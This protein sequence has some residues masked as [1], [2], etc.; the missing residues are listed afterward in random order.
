[1]VNLA[2]RVD[3]FEL[4][5]MLGT[6]AREIHTFYKKTLLIYSG[7]RIYFIRIDTIDL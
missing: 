7:T 3:A 6:Q 4:F 5:E 1:M 2:K